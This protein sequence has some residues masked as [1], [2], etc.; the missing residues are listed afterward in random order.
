MAAKTCLILG[1][2]QGMQWLR[3]RSGNAGLFVLQNG[4]IALSNNMEAYLV[5]ENERNILVES[6]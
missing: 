3:Q 5:K 1:S 4:I 2:E 6:I